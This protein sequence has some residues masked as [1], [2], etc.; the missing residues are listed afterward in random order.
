MGWRDEDDVTVTT[1]KKIIFPKPHI[2][3]RFIPLKP[4]QLPGA[5][6]FFFLL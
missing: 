3:M 2:V 4:Q 5:S 6:S 1:Q